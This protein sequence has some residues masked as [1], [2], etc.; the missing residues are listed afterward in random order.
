MTLRIKSSDFSCFAGMKYQNPENKEL[1][2]YIN[3]FKENDN[4]TAFQIE[5][6]CGN[7]DF[8][9][10]CYCHKQLKD[11]GMFT[12]VEYDDNGKILGYWLCFY[13]KNKN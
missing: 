5:D 7:M 11:C 9:V 3:I 8:D 12:K 2:E 1:D 10:V 13:K 4:L 6:R